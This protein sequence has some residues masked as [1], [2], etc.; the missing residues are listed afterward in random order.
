MKQYLIL[1]LLAVSL[2]SCDKKE[3]FKP[4]TYPPL[5]GMQG[6]VDNNTFTAQ[7][8]SSRITEFK[9]SSL[10]AIVVGGYNY[11]NGEVL[12]LQFA[13]PYLM[14]GAYKITNNSNGGLANMA[15]YDNG[16]DTFYYSNMGALVIDRYKDSILYGSFDFTTNK[17]NH[18]QGTFT[19][20][21]EYRVE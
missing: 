2:Y 12:L 17:G 21:P 1:L 5:E 6:N 3:S 20:K 9:D 14:P 4:T 18:V 8:V 19:T 11:D 16:N 13:I 7:S 10:F 15:A